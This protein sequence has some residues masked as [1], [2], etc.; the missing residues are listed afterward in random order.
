METEDRALLIWG[1]ENVYPM[2]LSIH[3][4]K[5]AAGTR[6][7]LMH[8]AHRIEMRKESMRKKRYPPPDESKDR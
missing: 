8:N 6:D 1:I 3:C 5:R 7:R 4:S 2:S